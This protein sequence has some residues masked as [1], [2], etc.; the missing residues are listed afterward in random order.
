MIKWVVIFVVLWAVSGCKSKQK[1]A[2]DFRGEENRVEQVEAVEH[3]E[4]KRDSTG[5]RV[6][7]V[8]SYREDEQETET[9]VKLTE[10]DTSKPV[11]E[12]T[13]RPPVLRETETV[14]K[15]RKGVREEVVEHVLENGEVVQ[16]QEKQSVVTGRN[17]V[18]QELDGTVEQKQVRKSGSALWNWIGLAGV[19][20]VFGILYLRRRH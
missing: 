3:E 13:G 14:T 19:V 7:E 1:L 15:Q 2:V 16:V 6:Q 17:E 4:V 9:V 10:Y 20:A 8:V 11:V 5:Q 12:N 18:R